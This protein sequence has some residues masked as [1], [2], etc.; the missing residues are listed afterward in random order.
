MASE[1]GASVAVSC[2]SAVTQRRQRQQARLIA[3]TCGLG[4]CLVVGDAGEGLVLELN[5]LGLSANG[6][7]LSFEGD[8]S[9]PVEALPFAD[10]AFDFLILN[11]WPSECKPAAQG[12][13]EVRRVV[14]RGA[15]INIVAGVAPLTPDDRAAW[16]ALCFEAGFRRHSRYLSVTDL[17]ELYRNVEVI[18]IPL[19]VVPERSGAKGGA[20]FLDLL[21]V[22]R[23]GAFARLACYTHAANLVRPG[24]RVVNLNCG[25]GAGSH[26]LYELS[27]A[28]R[29]VGFDA[30]QEHVAYASASYGVPDKIDFVSKEAGRALCD[31]AEASCDFLVDLEFSSDPDCTGRLGAILRSLAPAGRMVLAGA[32]RCP[33]ELFDELARNAIP[34]FR[35]AV[36]G[37]SD[38]I[39]LAGNS[40]P[41]SLRQ[42]D[43]SYAG[44]KECA[45]WLIVAMKSPL[46][47]AE[48]YVERVFSKVVEAGHPSLAYGKDYAN[49]WLMHSMVNAGWRIKDARALEAL[50]DRVLSAPNWTSADCLAALCVKVYRLLESLPVRNDAAAGVLSLLAD[51]INGGGASPLHLRWKVSLLFAKGRLLQS[52]GR[53]SEAME[54]FV[55]CGHHDVRSFGI[56]LA[57]KPTEALYL[58]GKIALSLDLPSEAKR[59]WTLGLEYGK[60]LLGASLD[61]ILINRD[62]PNRFNHGDGVREYALAWDNIARCANGIHLLADSRPVDHR[63]LDNCFQSE[64]AVVT[65]DVM[66]ARAVL[67][68]RTVR[69]ECVTADL[70]DRTERLEAATAEVSCLRSTVGELERALVSE[71]S[72]LKSV[73]GDLRERTAELNATREALV[74][75]SE[76]LRSLASEVESRTNELNVTRKELVERTERLEFVA[77]ELKA[78]TDELNSVRHEL[79]ERTSFLERVAGEVEALGVTL[80]TRTE[81]LVE[82]RRLVV[83][84]SAGWESTA[85]DL[86]VRTDELIRVREQLSECTARFE[87]LSVR[88]AAVEAQLVESRDVLRERTRELEAVRGILVERTKRLESVTCD[89]GIR[90]EE[91]LAVQTALNEAKALAARLSSELGASLQEL[92]ESRRR[93]ATTEVEL[94]AVRRALREREQEINDH[95]NA[96]IY[97]RIFVRGM[98]K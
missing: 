18:N 45:G 26:L 16:E 88:H 24:D 58:A 54:A 73:S 7:A 27:R 44:S 21:R 56:H 97:K 36:Q 19:A 25:S 35:F 38:E 13:M 57:T 37:L 94:D 95:L 6:Y 84:R 43:N 46:D 75:R 29:V 86:A 53:S 66:D 77:I 51:A 78:R 32:E 2:R 71:S 98:K 76:S 20:L 90:S 11:D 12:L 74:E 82:A 96:P 42:L 1:V 8:V 62:C 33:E 39:G 68:E 89:L 14:R 92:V 64:Y 30:H 85:A 50:A 22:V 67:V 41:P 52:L 40:L 59:C 34:E 5:R 72:M 10:A 9:R 70:I 23:E 81:E 47:T 49:P 79:V 63:A 3:E 69:L 65:D 55:L 28:E 61:D 17:D 4:S 91:F 60:S 15:F 93:G 83:E 48:E 87:A 31:L 80:Q